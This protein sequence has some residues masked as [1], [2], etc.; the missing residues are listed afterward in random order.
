MRILDQVFLALT[1]HPST[2]T[3]EEAHGRRLAAGLAGLGQGQRRHMEDLL[4]RQPELL[5]RRHDQAP[6]TGRRQHRGDERRHGIGEVFG[7]VEHRHH[8][9]AGQPS[10]ELA[11]QRR[12]VVDVD[13]Q[14]HRRGDRL[15]HH[16]LGRQVGEE[17]DGGRGG[18][19]RHVGG[20]ECRLARAARTGEGHQ[21]RG[22][23]MVAEL[24]EQFIAAHESRGP[25][26]R[27]GGGLLDG[28][29]CGRRRHR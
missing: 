19:R 18:E 13:D 6:R 21:P 4:P 22:P 2:P 7:V 10:G 26:R 9:A 17:D 1:R 28:R 3:G 16:P 8:L 11:A 27:R 15:E 25:W 23:E 5:A 24:G 20:G 14:P 29:R 12:E